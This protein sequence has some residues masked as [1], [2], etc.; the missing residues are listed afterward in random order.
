MATNNTKIAIIGSGFIGISTAYYLCLKHNLSNVFLIDI[1]NPMSFTSSQSGENYR[2][3]WP[4]PSMV[5]LMNRSIDLLENLVEITGNRKNISRRGYV[6][7]TRESNIRDLIDQL[8]FGLGSKSSSLIRYHK[9]FNKNNYRANSNYDFLDKPDG[10]D[11]LQDQKL[12]QTN[13]PSFSKDI[14]T[15]LHIRKG[16]QINSQQI[17]EFMMNFCKSNGHERI[18]GEVKSINL[19][20]HYTLQLQ[21]ESGMQS[22]CVDKI[23]NAAGPY[24]D[25]VAEMLDIK[26]PI[27]NILQQKIAFPDHLKAIPRD[28]PFSIDLDKQSIDWSS[29]EKEI[30]LT[31]PD[32]CFLAKQLPGAVHCRPEGEGDS[33]WLKLGWAY[34]TEKMNISRKPELHKY[35][36]EIVLR[37]AAQLN[38]ALKKYY[39]KLPKNF[40]HYGGWYTMTNENWPLIGPMVKEG[41]FVNSAFSGF[42][43]MAACAAGEL[44]AA[45]VTE[46]TLP[47]YA[48]NFSLNRYKNSS[49]MKTLNKINRGI[50]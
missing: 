13:F 35:F 9:K 39:G 46:S 45:W 17:A 25:K 30:I 37:G 31:D 40:V 12:I 47:K 43:T 22:I 23:V 34:S 44:C 15:I 50:L 8:R 5:D 18:K 11:V 33:Q 48:N 27:F 36:P 3:W 19:T 21:T 38:P 24:S 26:L 42:G 7:S 14:K 6:L 28:M 49:L 32:L 4:H 20:D 41:A 2:N 29:D 16:G 10:V 1:G